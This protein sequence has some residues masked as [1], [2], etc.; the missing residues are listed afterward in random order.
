MM[1]NGVMTQEKEK[2]NRLVDHLANTGIVITT[3]EKLLRNLLTAITKD[4]MD[5]IVHLQKNL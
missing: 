3:D 4:H 2:G 1:L 5:I